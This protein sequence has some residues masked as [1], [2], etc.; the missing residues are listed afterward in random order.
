MR[1]KCWEWKRGFREGYG[2]AIIDKQIVYA[3][4][5]SYALFNGGISKGKC[6]LHKCDNRKCFNPKHLFLGT[7]KE[8]AHDRDKKGRTQKGE[9]HYR[10][11]LSEVKVKA[12]RYLASEGITH[13]KIADKFGVSRAAI[14]QIT[15]KRNWK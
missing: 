6:V 14:T 4:R 15:L 11:K 10:T 1:S 2:I 12:I 9:K 7:R 13:Q 8:N 3:H 5:A